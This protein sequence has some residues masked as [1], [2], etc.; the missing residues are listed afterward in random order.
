[1]DLEAF[2]KYLK[3]TYTIEGNE[4]HRI[5]VA[6]FI[7]TFIDYIETQI[8]PPSVDTSVKQEQEEPKETASP[9]P[10]Q[11]VKVKKIPAKYV[12]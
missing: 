6:E 7:S 3:S 8:S 4:Y 11:K 12:E 9:L 5:T 10:I 1:M 2:S